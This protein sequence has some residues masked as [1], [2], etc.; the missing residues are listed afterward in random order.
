MSIVSFQNPGLIPIEAIT[1]MGVNA[2]E[3]ESPIGFFGTGLKYSIATLLRTG[4]KITI[5]RGLDRYDFTQEIGEVRGKEFG[6]VWRTHDSQRLRLGFT[7]H[8]GAK[9]EQW[10]IFRELYSNTLDESGDMELKARKPKEG[11]TTIIVEGEAFFDA[12]KK[13]KEVFLEGEPLEKT[14]CVEV[15][16]GAS[17]V[18]FYRG[19]RGYTLDKPMKHTYNIIAALDL[20]EDR[21]IK[22][23]WYIRYFL[24]K[25]LMELEDQQIVEDSLLNEEGFE[26]N[27]NFCM[28]N[29]P[30][31]HFP[32]T[33]MRLA[34]GGLLAKLPKHALEVSEKWAQSQAQVQPC[35]LSLYEQEQITEALSFL[36]E[37]GFNV[38]EQIIVTQT[39]GPNIWGLARNKTIMLARAT[40]DKGGSWLAGTILEEHLH[41]TQGFID[42]S[43]RFQNFLF[44]LAL[45]FARE[46]VHLRKAIA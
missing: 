41:I 2:K 30:S 19:V 22:D 16:P 35:E 33:V 1:V 39:L 9:W 26:E 3:N 28:L 14:D 10:Q 38:T 17:K 12:A 15:Y 43:R 8:L 20:T 37:I 32:K 27:L 45:R 21:T 5:F 24:V 29:P 23:E 18:V 11:F 6:F 36:K 25:A 13:K 46:A 40:I 44:D 42:E 34:A 7:T 4:Q 31:E